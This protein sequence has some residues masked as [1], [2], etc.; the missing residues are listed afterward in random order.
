MKKT[1]PAVVIGNWKMNPVS[2]AEAKKIFLAIR[3]KSRSFGEV[4]VVLAPPMVYLSELVKLSV[5]GRVQVGVQNVWFESVGAQTGEVSVPMVQSCGAHY[6]IIGHSERRVNGETDDMVQ[7]KYR[8]VVSAKLTPVVCI[9]EQARDDTGSFYS[10][11]ESQLKSCFSQA[12]KAEVKRTIIAYE[13]IWAIGSGTTPSAEDIQEMRLFIDKCLINLFDRDTA[14]KVKVLY[15]GSVSDE[16]AGSL[17]RAAGIDGFL[18]GGASL[19]PESFVGIV[20]AVQKLA[21]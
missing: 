3:K 20:Q 16:N 7:A 21:K 5:S 2:L 11:I 19:R 10:T 1:Q 14:R 18:V 6:V 13:P 15:G 17:Y 8:A 4:S 9:G 12:K